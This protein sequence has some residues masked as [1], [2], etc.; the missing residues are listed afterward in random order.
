MSVHADAASPPLLLPAD[1]LVAYV[2]AAFAVLWLPYVAHAAEPRLYVAAHLAGALLLPSLLER[3]AGQLSR[4]TRLVRDLYPLACVALMWGE[5]GRRWIWTRDDANDRFVASLDQLAFG[6][7]LHER[8]MAAVPEL[9]LVMHGAYFAYYLLLIGVPL[10]LLLRRCE[11]S[12][13]EL[14]LRVAATYLLCFVIAAA[15]PVRGPF[16]TT[17][18]AVTAAGADGGF[19]RPLILGIRAAGDSLGTAFPSTHTAG[20]VTFA[21]LLWRRFP[22]PWRGPAVTLAALI[23]LS[24]V[25][26]RNH[27]VMDMLAGTTVA[28]LAQ[29]W[30]V[31]ALQRGPRT[32]PVP[33]ASR[34]DPVTA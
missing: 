32:V 3:A 22:G 7:P 11:A 26:T 6:A 30:L 34:L 25:Y 2:H 12:R 9:G 21:V 20:A 24:T 14:A 27:F 10:A 13:Q 33:A 17:H 28:L 5:L 8:F 29:F 1:R 31:P 15:F 4:G 23:A 16:D 19:F 18:V